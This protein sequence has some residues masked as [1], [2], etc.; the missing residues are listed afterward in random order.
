M[1]TSIGGLSSG[2]DTTSLINSLMQVESQPQTTLKSKVSTQTTTNT[3]YQTVNGKM[4]ALLTASTDLTK[5]EAWKAVKA[6]SSSA[7]VV[8]TAATG[9][10]TGDMTFS[11]TKLATSHRLTAPFAATD[12][13]ATNDGTFSLTIGIGA[14]A[15]TTPLAVDGDK[16]TPQGVADAINKAGLAVRASVITT[17]AG[18]VLQ[19]ASTKTGAAN[20]F[21]IDGL[22]SAPAVMS[23]GSDAELTVGDPDAGG[24]RVSSSSNTFTGVMPGVTITA[25]KL[26]TDVT[27][28]V[29]SDTDAIA[30]KMQALVDAANGALAQITL[31]ASSGGARTS[32]SKSS[33]GPLAGDY[34]VRQLSGQVLS[35]VSNGLSG[36]SFKGLG[37]QLTSDGKLKFNKD[38]FLTAYQADPALTKERVATGL[39]ESMKVV[40]D[41]ATDSISGSLT[42]K[43]QSGDNTIS[44]LNKEIL[45]WDTK[46]AD[47]RTALQRQFSAME[48]AL[49][50]IS[51]QSSW[52][53]SQTAASS[54]S[55]GGS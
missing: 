30:A 24:F 26:A 17:D 28:G 9:A 34:T 37:V 5:D 14:D 6:T 4:K 7:D 49:S 32:G 19:L 23:P 16:N 36:F 3:A 8:A 21:T 54:A 48:T 1:V 33:G 41:A 10:L 55:S 20:E 39:A 2:L 43:I 12:S 27:I 25:N 11:V 51:S 13:Q 40:A 22:T 15:V 29:A 53:S 52:L 50:K 35:T 38:D 47:R 42:Q 46:L 44:R 18:P 31:S 45:D